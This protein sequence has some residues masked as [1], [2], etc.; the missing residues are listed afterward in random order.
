[1]SSRLCDWCTL[2]HGSLLGLTKNDRN[3]VRA[4]NRASKALNLKLGQLRFYATK[5]SDMIFV[6]P[7][8]FIIRM[9]S[10]QHFIF[11]QVENR[12]VNITRFGRWCDQNQIF[13]LL[14]R[15]STVTEKRKKMNQIK[16]ITQ[17]LIGIYSKLRIMLKSGC[18]IRKLRDDD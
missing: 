14:V 18:F 2:R 13:L 10:W 6:V 15:E 17:S 3:Y 9:R 11:F 8:L 12:S 7:S 4:R 16:K 1:M 5:C